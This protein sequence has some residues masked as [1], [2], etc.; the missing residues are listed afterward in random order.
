MNNIFILQAW[1]AN[2]VAPIINYTDSEHWQK[3]P[4][5]GKEILNQIGDFEIAKDD[6][7]SLT[8]D[9]AEM[10]GFKRWSE[11]EP[12]LLLIP[13]YLWRFIPSGLNLKSIN[14]EVENYKTFEDLDNDCRFGCLAYGLEIK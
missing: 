2:K 10:L 6:F 3:T 13:A 5:N 8:K 4:L 14:G 11:E 1:L 9:Q 12:D 7:E